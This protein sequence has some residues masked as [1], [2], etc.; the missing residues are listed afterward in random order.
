MHHYSGRPG[1][2]TRAVADRSSGAD[3]QTFRLSTIG[4]HTLQKSIAAA[5]TR[6]VSLIGVFLLVGVP[7]KA[8]RLTPLSFSK[9]GVIANDGHEDVSR[10]GR[11][12]LDH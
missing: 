4:G 7:T 8:N 2:M 12:L 10:L 3:L 5:D 1:I 11:P 6:R 9:N